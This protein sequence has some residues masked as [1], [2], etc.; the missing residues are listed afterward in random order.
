MSGMG[1]S[2]YG[3]LTSLIG[4]WKGGKGLDVAPVPDGVEESPDYETFDFAACG[5]A[6][7]AE[8]QELAVSVTSGDPD[9]GVIESPVMRDNAKTVSFS[10]NIDRRGRY[11]ELC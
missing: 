8:R 3:P 2:D 6:D 4:K 5:T 9:W 10:H 1:L 7:N 11:L